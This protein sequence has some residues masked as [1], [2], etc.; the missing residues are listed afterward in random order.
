MAFDPKFT[1]GWPIQEFYEIATRNGYRIHILSINGVPNFRRLG[2]HHDKPV[3]SAHIRT[4]IPLPPGMLQRPSLQLYC[5][6]EELIFCRRLPAIVQ[7]VMG[8]CFSDKKTI[9][10]PKKTIQEPP[11]DRRHC[12]IHREQNRQKTCLFCNERNQMERKE[13]LTI[14]QQ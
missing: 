4:S 9:E 14:D 11:I 3:L 1:K 10:L 7:D 5:Y 6:L 8:A 12:P 13:M 2:A